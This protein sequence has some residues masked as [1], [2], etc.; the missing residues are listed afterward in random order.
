MEIPVFSNYFE[1]SSTLM[2]VYEHLNFHTYL[3][4]NNG[5]VK[6]KVMHV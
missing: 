5:I 1:I 6:I 3:C 2:T 4:S